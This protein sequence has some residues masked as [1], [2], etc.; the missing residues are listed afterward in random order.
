MSETLDC[1]ECRFGRY[2]PT[3]FLHHLASRGTPF[4]SRK[5]NPCNGCAVALHHN[6]AVFRRYIRQGKKPNCLNLL[7]HPLEAAAAKQGESPK[8]VVFG[9]WK[10][11]P[12]GQAG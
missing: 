5:V 10:I 8:N 7:P 11:R 12:A 4:V 9:P 3:F 2:Y 6:Q 1:R